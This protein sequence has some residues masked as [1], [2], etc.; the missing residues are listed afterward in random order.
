VFVDEVGMGYGV[1]DRLRQLGYRVIGVNN[2]SKAQAEDRYHNK[3]AET[4]G[5]LKEWLARGGVLPRDVS[6]LTEELA[7]ITYDHDA[8]DRIVLS[9]KDDIRDLLGRSPD[10]ADALALTFAE[11]I[12]S[13]EVRALQSHR[14]RSGAISTYDPFA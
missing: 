11:R 2:A 9:P 12:A 14:N 13:P 6:D 10:L 7:A 8:Q 5:R 4:Y 1:I 3:R